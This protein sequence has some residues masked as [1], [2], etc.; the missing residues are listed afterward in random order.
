MFQNFL[1]N[2]SEGNIEK[3]KETN[4]KLNLMII[5]ETKEK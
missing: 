1:V 2:L 3:K 4:K 5:F